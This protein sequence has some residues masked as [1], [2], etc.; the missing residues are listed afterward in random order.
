M[1]AILVAPLMLRV[2]A[3]TPYI[4]FPKKLHVDFFDDSLK[5]ETC[6]DSKYGKYIE[7]QNKVYLRDSVIVVTV[8]G[9]TLRCHDLWWDQN[10]E[11]FYTDS[12]ATYLSPDTD[13]LAGKGMEATQDLKMVRFKYPT[14][15]VKIND[16]GF[17]EYIIIFPCLPEFE[18]EQ[19]YKSRSLR[20]R[21]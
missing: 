7:N 20:E 16:S 15:P 19:K 14:G 4:E 1:K 3:D 18:C 12:I 11:M 21:D 13:I 8:K 17:A 6:L 5:I 2:M 10:K 9:D